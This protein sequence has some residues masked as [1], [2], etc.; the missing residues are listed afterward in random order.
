MRTPFS[1]NSLVTGIYWSILL[2]LQAGY[3]WHLYAANEHFVKSAANVGSHFILVR[4]SPTTPLSSKLT[5]EPEQSLDF[6]VH[7]ALG[8]R[9][10][11]AVRALDDSQLL[12]PVLPL[13]PAFHHASLG[14]YPS[15]V[16]PSGLNLCSSLLGW[17]CDGSR[18]HSSC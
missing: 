10:L 4:S 3:I 6:R 12:E 7:H 15:R 14:S 2:V 16:R 1:L 8:P 5:S 18:S 11:L 9:P 17:C 13:P